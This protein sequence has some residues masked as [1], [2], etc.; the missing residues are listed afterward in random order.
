M[1]VPDDPSLT[2]TYREE[3]TMSTPS[4]STLFYCWQSDLPQ[5]ANR[6]LIRDALEK[7]LKT[8][9]T[10]RPEMSLKLDQDARGAHGT[11]DI[12]G[13][14]LRKIAACSVFVCDI[15][16]VNSHASEVV[17]FMPNPNVMF[18]LG[19]AV[20]TLGW[21]RIV[22]IFNGSYGQ[23]KDLPFDF[24]WR[25]VIQYELGEGASAQSRSEQQRALSGRLASDVE[26]ILSSAPRQKDIA[27]LDRVVAHELRDALNNIRVPIIV[28]LIIKLGETEPERRRLLGQILYSSPPNAPGSRFPDRSLA[29]PILDELNDPRLLQPCLHHEA[30]EG[31][32]WIQW[33]V[34]SCAE[35]V[36]ICERAID[37]HSRNASSRLIA[38]METVA[39][40]IGRSAATLQQIASTQ[41]Q[42][43]FHEH[44][45]LAFLESVLEVMF[46]AERVWREEVGGEFSLPPDLAQLRAK[47]P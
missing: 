9:A 23:F 31:V 37:R 44:S 8:V 12:P 7:A 45:G 32:P 42:D 40:T 46:R 4:E 24:G 13:V 18:E 39:K 14:L 29:K 26:E 11:V 5:T 38:Q 33:F 25:S 41:P 21:E 30:P 36:A 10:K 15:S 1:A 28:F 27:D 16:I 2:D 35:S 43:L 22:C 47:N 6:F 19:Y 3:A 34:S 20:A 17:R